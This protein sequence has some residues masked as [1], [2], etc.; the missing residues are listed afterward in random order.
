MSLVPACAARRIRPRASQA[1]GRSTHWRTSP[2]PDVRTCDTWTGARD[3]WTGASAT[4][5]GGGR[6]VRGGGAQPGGGDLVVVLVELL[7]DLA[8]RR[9][10]DSNEALR[11][12]SE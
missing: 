8:Q 2:P 12:V 3:T 6:V 11:Q 4:W 10:V 1:E 7:G 9:L 5:T